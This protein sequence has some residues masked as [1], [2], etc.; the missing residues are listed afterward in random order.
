LH[1]ENVV[2][3]LKGVNHFSIKLMVFPAGAKV[4]IFGH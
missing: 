2:T 1:A 3:I 4:L